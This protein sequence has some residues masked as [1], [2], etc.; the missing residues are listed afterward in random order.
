M[1]DSHGSGAD[2]AEPDGSGSV[3]VRIPKTVLFILVAVLV[4]ATAYVV[5]STVKERVTDPAI[6]KAEEAVDNAAKDIA[7]IPARK[8]A[9]EDR[10]E[11]LANMFADAQGVSR[12]QVD[13]CSVSKAFYLA[14]AREESSSRVPWDDA[15][16]IEL[17]MFTVTTPLGKWIGATWKYQNDSEWTRE[18]CGML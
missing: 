15:D 18:V 5:G 17:Y 13:V 8:K 1:T 2:G 14:N 16:S 7:A 9:E 12:D 10:L 4:L 6:N 11:E 3:T